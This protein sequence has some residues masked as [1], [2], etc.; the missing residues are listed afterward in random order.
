MSRT[1]RHNITSRAMQRPV[2]RKEAWRSASRQDWLARRQ[3]ARP[4]HVCKRENKLR[5]A[6]LAM[7]QARRHLE[8]YPSARG[9]A[10]ALK[11]SSIN[12]A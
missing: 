2:R 8:E 11:N 6:T 5:T 12:F 7:L 4:L 9:A 10:V 1:L 3:A